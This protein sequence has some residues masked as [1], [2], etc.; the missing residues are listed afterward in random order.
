MRTGIHMAEVEAIDEMVARGLTVVRLEPA[1]IELWREQAE[2]IYPRL[3]CASE[4]PAIF[5]EVMRL[6][7]P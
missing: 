6:R 7:S 5:A 3:G 2:A 4:H 1:E